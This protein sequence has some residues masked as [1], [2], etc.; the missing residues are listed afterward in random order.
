[1]E[2]TM[3]DI[4]DKIDNEISF[5]PVSYYS[6]DV[7]RIAPA[8]RM[9]LKKNGTSIVVFKTNDLILYYIENKRDF[10]SIFSSVKESQILYKIL[11]PIHVIGYKDIDEQYSVIKEEINKRENV[12]MVAVRGTGVF[13]QG[14]TKAETDSRV[15]LFL[16]LVKVK[17]YISLKKEI[18]FDEIESS[19]FQRYGRRIA[20]SQYIDKKFPE[21]IAI[22][23]GAAQGF[24]KG[25]AESLAKEGANV[26]LADININMAK[27]NI[28]K[29]NKEYG[30]G[31]VKA[32]EIDVTD[33]VQVR[34]MILETVVEY[35]GIDI[36]ISNAG[37]LK[38]GGLESIDL[39]SFEFSTKVNYTAFFICTK[40]A[41]QPMK[42]QYKFDSSCFADIIQVN[43]KSG[44]EGSKKNF[45]YAG[46]KFGGIGLTQ[47]FALE[48]IEFNIKVNAVCPGNFFEGP[49]WSDPKRGLF[50][51]YLK[52]NKVPGAKT[53]G[54][55]RKFYEGKVPMKRGCRIEDLVKAIF[56]VIEQ[57]Y[58]T[59]QA[60]PVTG[61]QIMIH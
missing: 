48:L 3:S 60:I 35:G 1:M 32:L 27:K 59:G 17:K 21:K 13:I 36:F 4:I 54:D 38:A 20:K 39:K 37:I 61:G 15:S 6:Q 49:L 53:I 50:I 19:L 12:N 44:L 23:T 45:I 9:L 52:A 40:H 18:S 29:L 22:V 28:L 5:K 11:N 10:F 7:I 24:G 25:I 55:V 41:S 30:I 16:D 58:E 33:E 51:Q 31:K 57:K 14:E 46:S 2:N 47:S 26:I 34:R 42:I 56:Y 8:L 43:S